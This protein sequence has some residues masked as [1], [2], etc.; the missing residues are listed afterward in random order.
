M[1][2]IKHFNM[3]C[4][5]KNLYFEG[6][7]LEFVKFQASTPPDAAASPPTSDQPAASLLTPDQSVKKYWTL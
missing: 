5:L 2:K 7:I 3:I 6:A 1:K 4:L